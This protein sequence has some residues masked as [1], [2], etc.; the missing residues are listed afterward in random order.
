MLHNNRKASA[1][2]AIFVMVLLAAFGIDRIGG[3]TWVSVAAS[4]SAGWHARVGSYM[5]PPTPFWR[6]FL[7]PGILIL[8]AVAVALLGAVLN[9]LS[10]RANEPE[11]DA[12]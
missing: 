12:R 11:Q 7:V 4:T 2:I 8:S 5:P 10:N 1:A 9:R 3:D 6:T